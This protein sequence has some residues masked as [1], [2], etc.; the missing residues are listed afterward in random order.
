MLCESWGFPGD[1][2]DEAALHPPSAAPELPSP[3]TTHCNH[4]QQARSTADSE[5]ASI[6]SPVVL[7]P[8]S[9]EGYSEGGC[10]VPSSVCSS[11]GSC[12]CDCGRCEGRASFALVSVLGKMRRGSVAAPKVLWFESEFNWACKTTGPSPCFAMQCLPVM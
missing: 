7:L 6:P 4:P 11:L 10:K 2:G 12:G 8:V 9:P 1:C 3:G 5:V